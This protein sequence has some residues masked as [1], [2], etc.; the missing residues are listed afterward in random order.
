M[1]KLTELQMFISSN[2]DKERRGEQIKLAKQLTSV[3]LVDIPLFSAC[4]VS[5]VKTLV[6]C[7]VECV[8]VILLVS[9]NIL[10]YCTAVLLSDC[11]LSLNILS[12]SVHNIII[13]R[14]FLA[15]VTPQV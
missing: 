14:Q 7:R 9:D 8:I 1:A 2:V 15:H 10:L 3:V 12:P 5:L 11:G 6:D 4:H 13:K